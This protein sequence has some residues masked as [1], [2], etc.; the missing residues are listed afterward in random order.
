MCIDS[1]LF[2]PRYLLN[3][4]QPCFSALAIATAAD[5]NKQAR[6]QEAEA[7]LNELPDDDLISTP[8]H[9]PVPT[10]PVAAHG[11]ST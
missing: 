1:H 5:P 4:L 10:R 7:Y 11:E 2:Q 8:L 9:L 6:L 3:L